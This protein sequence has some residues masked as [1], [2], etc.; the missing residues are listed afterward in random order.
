MTICGALSFGLAGC[1]QEMTERQIP[2]DIVQFE[3]SQECINSGFEPK[4][5]EIG[6]RVAMAQYFNETPKYGYQLECEKDWGKNNCHQLIQ[7]EDVLF[8]PAMV[9]YSL[10]RSVEEEY[11]DF[12]KEFY[13]SDYIWAAPFYATVSG[14]SMYVQEEKDNATFVYGK[15]GPD[16]S[17]QV[18]MNLENI[19]FNQDAFE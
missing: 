13:R 19:S 16:P 6:Y 3:N 15:S 2:H 9:G 7:N 10:S 5:C 18:T 14:A 12:E 17:R 11:P 8:M 1:N 4:G